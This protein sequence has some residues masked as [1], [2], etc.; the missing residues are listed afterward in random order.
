[1]SVDIFKTIQLLNRINIGIFACYYALCCF[2][3]KTIYMSRDLLQFYLVNVYEIT[4]RIK[5]AS[6][7][8][9]GFMN[10]ALL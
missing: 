9:Y 5:I 4:W 8:Q 2:Y 10:L 1:M 7:L 6:S 3:S